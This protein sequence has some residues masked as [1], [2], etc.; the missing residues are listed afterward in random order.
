MLWSCSMEPC[1]FDEILEKV[2]PLISKQ[3]TVMR[4]AISAHDKLCITMRFLA[5][6]ASY[7]DLMYSFSVSTASISKFVPE[8]CQAIYDVL[9]E[10]YLSAPASTT[11]W[12]PV[13]WWCI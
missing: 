4:S 8:V 11:Q 5:S 2:K 9:H 3:D 10:D 7:K 6:G 1:F 12:K 13:R